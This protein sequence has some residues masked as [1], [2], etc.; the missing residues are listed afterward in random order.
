MSHLHFKE[1]KC[2]IIIFFLLIVISIMFFELIQNFF[3]KI[4]HF[5]LLGFLSFPPL[6]F[7]LFLAI[8]VREL[9]LSAILGITVMISHLLIFYHGCTNAFVYKEVFKTHIIMILSVIYGFI[10]AYCCL[11][12]TRMEGQYLSPNLSDIRNSII[13]ISVAV[14][15]YLFVLDRIIDS[16]LAGPG[17]DPFYFGALLLSFIFLAI[18]MSFLYLSFGFFAQL[19]DKKPN[20]IILIFYSCIS[21]SIG[22]TFSTFLLEIGRIRDEFPSHWI[23][24][25]IWTLFLASFYLVISKRRMG[26]Y[27]GIQ[28][29]VEFFLGKR[30]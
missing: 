8:K 21:F 13:F 28:N 6:I 19:P 15:I 25:C 20:P 3:N 7:Q 5:G 11:L 4:D 12:G 17:S 26:M 10:T 14:I 9:Y 30:Y 22:V 23:F 16:L 24:L 1:Y 29:T 2:Y 18:T 27:T